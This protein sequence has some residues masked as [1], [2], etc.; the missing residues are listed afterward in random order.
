MKKL[1]LILICL[2]A[3]NGYSQIVTLNGKQSGLLNIDEI[4]N[5]GRLTIDK[6]IIKKFTVSTY[7]KG[8]VMD[9]VSN[10]LQFTAQQKMNMLKSEAGRKIYIEDIQV[11]TNDSVFT[12]K[13]L[14]F[15][16]DGPVASAFFERYIDNNKNIKYQF[17]FPKIFA[18]PNMTSTDTSELKVIQFSINSR[19]ENEFCKLETNSNTFTKQMVEILKVPTFDFE[20]TDIIAVNKNKDTLLIDDMHS[21]WFNTI[22]RTKKQLLSALKPDFRIEDFNIK[23]FEI[24]R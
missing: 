15:I 5:L 3:I 7:S 21:S 17:Q 13:P 12:V 22:I 10:S 1:F 16:K 11:Q 4:S 24:E 23:Y 2:M 18:Y 6:G 9:D 19:H 14:V 8:F 20:I